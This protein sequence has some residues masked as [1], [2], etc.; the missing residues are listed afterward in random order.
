VNGGTPTTARSCGC[1]GPPTVTERRASRSCGPCEGP[2]ASI[3]GVCSSGHGVCATIRA[4]LYRPSCMMSGRGVAEMHGVT[5]VR[6][7][8]SEGCAGVVAIVAF[9]SCV[10]PSAGSDTVQQ[11]ELGNGVTSGLPTLASRWLSL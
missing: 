2:S 4:R 5:A 11:P 10:L 7:V 8:I 9:T 3:D 1:G 6:D